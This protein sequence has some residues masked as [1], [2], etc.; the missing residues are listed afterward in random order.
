[1]QNIHF[2]AFK[3][4][5][6]HHIGEKACKVTAFLSNTQIFETKNAIY[7]YFLTKCVQKRNITPYI[8]AYVREK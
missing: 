2:S 4:S 5:I 6:Y 7:V 3:C 1:M 8:L